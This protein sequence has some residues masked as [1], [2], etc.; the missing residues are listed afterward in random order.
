MSSPVFMCWEHLP[1]H[2]ARSRDPRARPAAP[3]SQSARPARILRTNARLL[4]GT[5]LQGPAL[6]KLLS[7]EPRG[8]ITLLRVA[9]SCPSLPSQPPLPCRTLRSNAR[10]RLA[11]QD[12][13]E[14]HGKGGVVGSSRLR[15]SSVVRNPAAIAAIAVLAAR[16]PA[17]GGVMSLLRM[18][19]VRGRHLSISTAEPVQH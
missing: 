16:P 12:R 15:A 10:L 19:P 11:E 13:S 9:T 8:N 1:T 6:M 2:R 17:R 7:G 14:F 5:V 4:V 18:P 3:A